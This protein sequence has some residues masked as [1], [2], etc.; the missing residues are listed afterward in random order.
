MS[1]A[2]KWDADQRRTGKP[3]VKLPPAQPTYSDACPD[4]DSALDR[5]CPPECPANADATP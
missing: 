1:P 3:V 5:R 2:A 4:C